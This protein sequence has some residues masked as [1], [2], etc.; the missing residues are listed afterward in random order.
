MTKVSAPFAPHRRGPWWLLLG[1]LLVALSTAAWVVLS[2][3]AAQ[4]VPVD[5]V[6]TRLGKAVYAANC[7]ACH[8]VTGT[9]VRTAVPALAGTVPALLWE[10]GGREYLLAVV[11]NGMSGELSVA[12]ERYHGVMPSWNHLS[13]VQLASVLNYLATGWRNVELLPGDALAFTPLEV[14][15]ARVSVKSPSEIVKSRPPTNR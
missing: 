14:A 9:G 3:A 12:G 4:G 11:L 6:D 8:Q 5:L 15:L 10:E 13:D 2:P 7:A 1:S